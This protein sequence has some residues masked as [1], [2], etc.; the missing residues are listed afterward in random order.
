MNV[1]ESATIRAPSGKDETCIKFIIDTPGTPFVLHEIAQI[2]QEYTLSFYA[3]SEALGGITA[4][5]ISMDTSSE[6]QRYVITFPAESDDV[7]LYFNATGTYYIHK[8][9]LEEGNKD[10]TWALAPEDEEERLTDAITRI[11]ANE[12]SIE[13]M[14]ST[15]ES[16]SG[17]LTTT[18]SQISILQENIDLRVKYTDLDAYSTTAQMEAAI[19]VSANSITQTVSETYATKKEFNDLEVGG[20]NLLL[21]TNGSATCWGFS[22]KSGQYSITNKEMMG[23]TGIEVTIDEVSTGYSTLFFRS[24]NILLDALKPSS[25]YTISFDLLS[26]FDIGDNGECIIL[27]TASYKNSLTNEVEIGHVPAGVRTKVQ[28]TLKTVSEFPEIANQ[29][30]YIGNINKIGT[31]EICNLKMEYGNKATDW[32]PAPEDTDSKIASLEDWKTE[33]SQKITKDG[34]INT[35]GNYYAYQDDLAIAEN[36]ITAAE[37]TLTQHT[38]EIALKVAKDGVIGAINLSS[39]EVKI[40]AAKITLEGATIADNFTTTNLT[41]TGGSTF[42]G[43]LNGATGAFTGSVTATTLIATQGGT[44]GGWNIDSNSLYSSTSSSKMYIINGSNSPGDFLVVAA[45]DSSGA[46]SNYPFSVKADGTFTATKATISGDITAKNIA[47]TSTLKMYNP[48]LNKTGPVLTYDDDTGVLYVGGTNT[49]AFSAAVQVWSNLIVNQS[50]LTQYAYIDQ[51]C[52]ALHYHTNFDCSGTWY[53]GLSGANVAFDVPAAGAT[54]GI[55]WLAR[56]KASDGAWGMGVYHYDSNNFYLAYAAESIL[57]A[58]TNGYTTLYKFGS[59][60]VFTPSKGIKLYNGSGIRS[61]NTSGT[62]VNVVTWASDNRVYLGDEST[63][64][65][66]IRLAQT[67][68]NIGVLNSS[69][70]WITITTGVSDIREKNSINPLQNC[71]DIIMG[72]LPKR[73][74]Y[75]DPEDDRWHLGFVAQDVRKTLDSTIGDCAILEYNNLDPDEIRPVDR[76]DESTFTYSMRYTELIAP[77]IALTQ[78][79]EHRLVNTE[80]QIEI[81]QYRLDQAYDEIAKL[82]Q[83]LAG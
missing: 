10:T 11:T 55:N 81:L 66:K 50:M 22:R 5:G 64:A 70:S 48:L 31:I 40:N 63:K 15:Q 61:N 47:V 78:D 75:N 13:L 69:G 18:E 44:I 41:V 36:R 8:I 33:A 65:T 24:N 6:W 9:Q 58:G 60:G 49:A 1:R 20:R 77:H 52:H 42:S 67:C 45:L 51:D 19:N 32:T 53:N 25:Y 83:Q 59:N 4:G 12:S 43:V 30:V 73:F 80:S 72:L 56:V 29:I 3:K 82:K 71:K 28:A 23:V 34:I 62:E 74:K 26:T 46:V 57:T 16:F 76:N 17:R 27:T 54:T 38:D 14:V 39:E 7:P 2:G 68:A 37:S 79:H 21:N 35:V